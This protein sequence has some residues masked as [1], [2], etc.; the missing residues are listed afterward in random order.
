MKTQQNTFSFNKEKQETSKTR[1]SQWDNPVISVVMPVHN[2]EVFVQDAIESILGQTFENFE[3]IIIDDASSDGTK[4]ILDNIKDSR[5]VRLTNSVNAGNYRSRNRGLEICKGKYICI[6]DAD[7]ISAPDRLE[8]QFLFM[9]ENLHFAIAGSD[10]K[11]ISKG[12]TPLPSQRLRDE[13]EIKVKL[14]C[15]NVCTHS[16]LIIR[17]EILDKYKIR[18][19]EDYY[20]SADYKLLVDISRVGHITNIPEFLLFYRL[21]NKQITSTMGYEQKIYRNQIQIAQLGDFK[22]R[23]SVEEIIIHQ[24]LMN[25]LYLSKRQVSIAEKWCNKLLAKNHVI[26]IFNQDYLYSFLE[27]KI[28]AILNK[29]DFY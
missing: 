28:V 16:S 7:D 12:L 17:K 15:D 18:Y 14:L 24:G 9:E 25:V 29:S 1:D 10:I 13:Q 20:Y 8:K 21:H 22:I 23:P 2:M 4:E 5:I 27:G 6:M 19:N 3:F 11:F 26:N